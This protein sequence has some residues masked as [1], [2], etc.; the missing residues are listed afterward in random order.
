[1]G[2]KVAG[3]TRAHHYGEMV[4]TI[5]CRWAA[6]SCCM[7]TA[8][9]CSMRTCP[10]PGCCMGDSAQEEDPLA[11]HCMGTVCSGVADVWGTWAPMARPGNV[12]AIVLAG[13]QELAVLRCPGAVGSASFRPKRHSRFRLRLVGF[14]VR[15]LF[16]PI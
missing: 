15:I 2:N 12:M 5:V 3:E 8:A 13:P 7:V 6:N 16:H 10:N 1:M 4:G 11:A 9:V 14:A